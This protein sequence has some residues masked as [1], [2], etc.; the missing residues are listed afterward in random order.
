MHVVRLNSN[1][2]EGSHI[3]SGEIHS[4]RKDHINVDLIIQRIGKAHRHG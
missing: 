4:L 2:L 1:G 3:E